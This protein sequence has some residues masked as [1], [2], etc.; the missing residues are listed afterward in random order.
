M[1][2]WCRSVFV[3]LLLV[4]GWGIGPFCALE[5]DTYRKTIL[6]TRVWNAPTS[7]SSCR[8]FH[9]LGSGSVS[10]TRS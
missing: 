1:L 2:A 6:G 8:V 7:Y 9:S 4:V 5:Y 3:V 10:H